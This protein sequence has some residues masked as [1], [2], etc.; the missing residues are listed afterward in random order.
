MSASAELACAMAA[1]TLA[2]RIERLP[3]DERAILDI[4]LDRLEQGRADYGPWQVDDGR[5]NVAEAFDEILDAM[6][7]TA[8]GL[9][10]LKRSQQG[11]VR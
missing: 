4:L 2:E 7:Y 5:D 11:G 3:A 8:A 1:V 9:V 6:H 10:R